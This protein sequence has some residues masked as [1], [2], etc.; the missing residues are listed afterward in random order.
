MRKTVGCFTEEQLRQY[1]E[2][3]NVT[4]M[5]QVHD[6]VYQPWN[7]SLVMK[8]SE[9]VIDMANQG[10]SPEEMRQDC[11]IRTFAERYVTF[12]AK[13]SDA[14]FVRDLDNVNTVKRLILLRKIVDEGLLGE[15]DAKAQSAD[16]ALKSLIERVERQRDA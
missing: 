8:I 13:L 2:E 9:R 12:F 15:E 14:S 10:V 5:Q 3:P 16:I 1:A 7:A 6:N 4:V 11:E